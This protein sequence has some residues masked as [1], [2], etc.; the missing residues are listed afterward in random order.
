MLRLDCGSLRPSLGVLRTWT[1][2]AR[3]SWG[4]LAGEAPRA[5][6]GY[7]SGKGAGIVAELPA[8]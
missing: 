5:G 3:G 6:Y 8:W 4:M 1:L 7:C 2:G